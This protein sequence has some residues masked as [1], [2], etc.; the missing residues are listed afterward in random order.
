VADKPITVEIKGVR[1]FQRGCKTLSKNIDEQAA[2]E[3][4]TVAD[5]TATLVRAK[6]PKLTGQLAASVL[7]RA[8][9]DGATVGYGD[10]VYAGPVD[11][12]GWPKTRPYL[13]QGRWLLPTAELAGHLLVR[14]GDRAANKEIGTMRWP[15]PTAL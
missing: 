7:G 5:Q 14:A 15:T 6:V 13:Q 11:Y 8:G 3:F 12:G 1:E 2:R 4:R 10:L 9:P